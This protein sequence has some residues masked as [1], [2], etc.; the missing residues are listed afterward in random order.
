MLDMKT[1]AG[2]YLFNIIPSY[3]PGM[4]KVFDYGW[5]K[6]ACLPTLPNRVNQN[7]MYADFENEA[8]ENLSDLDIL[9]VFASDSDDDF[10]KLNWIDPSAYGITEEVVNMARNEFGFS[11]NGINYLN[12]HW[13]PATDGVN[14]TLDEGS[15]FIYNDTVIATAANNFL[16]GCHD[17]GNAGR[18]QLIPKSFTTSQHLFAVNGAGT[19][20]VGSSVSTRGFFHIRRTADNDLSLFKNGAQV[21]VTATTVASDALA[22]DDMYILANNSNGSAANMITAQVGIFGMGASLAGKEAAMNAAWDEYFA[23]L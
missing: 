21:G 23:T 22:N 19:D 12:T 17:T 14:F 20:S 5:Y 1:K 18:V 2:I 13:D 15:A 8:G 16:F 9:Y 4:S 11:S 6:L 10:A 3:R 7:A